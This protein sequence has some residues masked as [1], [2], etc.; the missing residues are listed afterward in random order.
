[1]MLA[2]SAAA[3]ICG[4]AVKRILRLVGCTEAENLHR[5]RSATGRHQMRNEVVV[6]VRVVR[7]SVQHHGSGAAAREIADVQASATVR[8]LCSMK[9][10]RAASWESVMIWLHG[11]WGRSSR[12]RPTVET[13]VRQLSQPAGPR[14]TEAQRCSGNR[15]GDSQKDC[16]AP[17][18]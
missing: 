10:G 3:S 8:D 5:D 1:M 7:K 14:A 15:P 4:Q 12:L 6:D 17:G 18:G 16:D 9:A 11:G 13:T 2:T